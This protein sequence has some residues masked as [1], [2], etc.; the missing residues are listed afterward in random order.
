MRKE[1]IYHLTKVRVLFI[2]ILLIV[3]FN[4]ISAQTVSTF[5]TGSGLY[6]PDGFALDES[7]NLYVAN[8]GGGIGNN[9]LK[10][11]SSGVVSTYATGFNA[12]DGLVFDTEGNLYVSNF[13][14]GVINKVTPEGVIS[15]FAT[16][17]N[18]PSALQFDGEG[19]LYVSN[20]GNGAGTTVS[21]ISPE[22]VIST[23]ASGFSAPLGLVFDSAWNLYVSN[24]NTG[25]I[26][27][28]TPAG[29]VGNFA[30]I[31]NTTPA[32]LQYLIFDDEENLYVP[33]YGHNRIYKINS[34]GRVSVFAGSLTSG[35]T[36]G[37]VDNAR[38]DGPNSIAITS[39]GIIYVAEYNANRIRRIIPAIIKPELLEPENGTEEQSSKNL[40]FLWDSV[41][42]STFYNFEMSTSSDFDSDLVT[43]RVS[44]NNTTIE[45]LSL[46]TKYYWR[47]TAY[48][49]SDQ[50]E[51][52]D[53]FSFTTESASYIY[54]IIPEMEYKLYPNPVY[55]LL[56]ISWNSKLDAPAR[57]RLLS[58]KGEV[59]FCLNQ[60]DIV[61]NPIRVELFNTQPGIYFTE[62]IQ[63]D[64]KTIVK[65]LIVLASVF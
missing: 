58:V 62:I 55:D 65:K 42:F 54:N 61:T 38:F 8:W 21:K 49:D 2:G 57:I 53:V 11:T 37:H 41:A 18:N 4:Q 44:E 7:E 23:F 22:G 20:H 50:T 26:N 60:T 48:S 32:I 25:I 13:G 40:E 43:V 33:S 31:S 34:E 27:K 45:T 5:V 59:I 9:V 30:S 56:N 10:I 24:Y 14:S 15:I 39:S 17:L 46:N 19:N 1:N 3:F 36:N 12:P 52:S 16:G 64:N 28:V 6:G 29:V 35:G 63:A 47:V 51:T